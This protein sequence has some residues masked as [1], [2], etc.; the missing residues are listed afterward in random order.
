MSEKNKLSLIPLKDTVPFPGVITSIIIGREL[1][2]RGVEYALTCS[3][4]NPELLLVAQS[5]TRAEHP[6]ESAIYTIGAVAK[7][8]QSFKLPNG[9]QKVMLEVLSRVEVSN[10]EF[11]S[12]IAADHRLAPETKQSYEDESIIID[13][14]IDGFKEYIRLN[15]TSGLDMVLNIVQ[16]QD[17]SFEQVVNSIAAYCLFEVEK[18]QT[19]LEID[20]IYLRGKALLEFIYA[21]NTQMETEQAVQMRLQDEIKKTHKEFYLNQ[22]MKAIQ[23]EL[24]GGSE[25]SEIAELQ[26]KVNTLNLSDEA[27]EKALSEIKKL[28]GMSSM[29]SEAT[30]IRNYLDILLDLPWGNVAKGKINVLQAQKV[31]DRDHFGMEEIKRRVIEYISV[32]QRS[33]QAKAPILCLIGPPGVGKT[34]LVKSIASAINRAYAKFA[35]GGMRDEAEIRGHRR[36]YI[37]AIPGRII[38]LLR[39][40]KEDNVVMLLDEIDKIGSDVRGDPASALLEVLD[41]EQNNA[42]VD[43]YLDCEYDLSKVIFIATANSYHNIPRP[44]YDR[45]EMIEIPGY[46]EMEK[47][48]ILKRYLVPKQLALHNMKKSEFSITDEAALELIRYY[49]KES[50]VRS[51][52]RRLASLMRKCLRKILE[53][54]KITKVKVTKDCLESYLG[55]HKHRFGLAEE[56]D[57]IGS[58]TGLAYTEL[59]GE[60]LTIEALSF[61]G[62]GE[63]KVT[64]KLG[65]VMKESVQA[66][67]SVFKAKSSELGIE[68]ANYKDL[69]VHLHVP[70]GAVPKDGPSAGIAIFTAIV[71]LFSKKFVRREVAMTG[72]ITLSGKVL[73]IGGLRE[74]LLAAKRGGITTVIIPKDNNK[75]LVEIPKYVYEGVEIV[76]V[77]S[78]DQVL[79]VA[80]R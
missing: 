10:I 79:Q 32:L 75:D 42:F 16:K 52:E 34:S 74:K 47:L 25:T 72:E 63:I 24:D 2:L 12:F 37:G 45:L 66:A 29:S 36:T 9:G 28:K 46:V 61:P 64:G 62:K 14:I 18:K 77:S 53:D 68:Y 65:E 58:T 57:Q 11:S 30:V 70:E 80:F 27:R 17:V 20:D 60:L 41:P 3:P 31:L 15:R 56:Q 35:L 55:P 5:D 51:L 67:H 50:G 1:S 13:S 71:S 22:Q 44:L 78:T 54:K 7:L 4:D 43:H 26:E 40:H 38:N 48:E 73:P 69:D 23:K 59:G 49:T 21:A 19:L 8:L 6:D 76:P 33:E 39:K